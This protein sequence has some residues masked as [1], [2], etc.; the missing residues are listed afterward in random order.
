MDFEDV[1]YKIIELKWLI[2]FIEVKNHEIMDFPTL[3]PH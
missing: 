2:A 1:S 3:T